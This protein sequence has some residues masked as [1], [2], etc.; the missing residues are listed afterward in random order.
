MVGPHAPTWH[1]TCWSTPVDDRAHRSGRSATLPL[2]GAEPGPGRRRVPAN[3]GPPARPAPPANPGPPREAEYRAGWVHGPEQPRPQCPAG[4]WGPN[5]PGP[6]A[7]ARGARVGGASGDL[8]GLLR[9]LRHQCVL[10]DLVDLAGQVEGHLLPDR[11]GDVL[12]VGAVALG[13]D[14]LL[15]AG[16]VGGQDLLLDPAD[17]QD[18]ALEGDLAGHADLGPDRPAGEQA[19]QGGGHGHAGRGAVL[20]DGARRDVD[21]VPA[22]GHV[23]VDAQLAGVGPD[24]GEGDRGRLLQHVAQLAGQ[25]QPGLTVHHAGLDEQDVTAGAGDG[26]AGRDPGDGGPLGRLEEEPLASQVAAHVAVVDDQRG[27]GL[28]AGD[29]GRRLAQQLADLTLQ[30]PDPGL[31]GVVADHGPQGR[32]GDDHLV[33]AQPGLVQLAGQQVVAGDGQLLVLGVA[34]QADDLHAVKQRAR[35]RL[36][37]VGGGDEQHVR[38]VQLDLEVVV[39]EGV[40]L[41]RVEH[42]EQGRGGVAAPVGTD[43]VDLVEQEHRVH[44]PGLLDGPGDPAGLGADIGAPV[45]ADLGLVADAAE[46]DPDELAA[47]GPGDRLAQRGLADTRRADQGDDRPGAAPALVGQAP[48]AAELAHGQVLEDAVLHVLEAGVVGVQDPPGLGDV[49]GVGGLLAPGQ[50]G[51]GVEPGPDPA[52]L[53]V[54]LAGP[55]QAADLPLDRLADG[56]GHLALLDLGPVG[57][58]RALAV[59]ALAELLADGGQLLAQDELAL[60]LLHPLGH[61]LADAVLELD[62]AQG[63]PAPGEHLLEALLDVDRLQHLDLLLERQVR[64]VDGGVGDLAGVGDA[65]QQLG[66]LGGAAGL[67]DVLD[68]GPV[69]AGKLHGPLGGRRVV[70]RLDLD[71]GGGPGAGHAGPDAGPVQAAPDHRQLPVGQLAGVLDLGDGADGGVAAVDLGDEQ[72]VAAGVTG[73]AGRRTRLGRLQGGGDDHSRQHDPAGQGQEGEGLDRELGHAFSRSKGCDTLINTRPRPHIP[74][75]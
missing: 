39:P 18:P 60:A 46:G 28:A 56:L 8:G 58:D 64:G 9:A 67:E 62:L 57:V 41:G 4:A 61:V 74:R 43:L 30:V 6:S 10:E 5:D 17:G 72:Q 14:D 19:G 15:E 75:A 52:V 34:V 54:L 65:P 50:L 55:L 70:D 35:D 40:V 48:L 51:H 11:L 13:D 12:Q 59:L 49:Q 2:R 71:P 27:A 33:A 66:D 37:H 38:Q 36:D 53:G 22:P 31:A 45:A 26:Q 23:A 20:G 44:G 42:L 68:H 1:G 73:G 25:G 21:M 24:V 69:L 7:A 47:H 3:Q 29:P 63:V 32:L 16:P